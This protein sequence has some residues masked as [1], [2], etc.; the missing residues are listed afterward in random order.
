VGDGRVD[1][2]AT[3]VAV[4]TGLGLKDPDTGQTLVDPP[5]EAEPSVG[6]VRDAL[7]W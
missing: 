7:G 6:S 4:L 1:P 2:L 3:I 5:L